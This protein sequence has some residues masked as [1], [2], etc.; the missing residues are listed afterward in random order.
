MEIFG[1]TSPVKISKCYGAVGR[2][3][4]IICE[5]NGING[6]GKT[7]AGDRSYDPVRRDEATAGV[8]SLDIDGITEQIWYWSVEPRTQWHCY[9]GSD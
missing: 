5:E 3:V 2:D 7:T 8:Q 1:N 9:V 4:T 6:D